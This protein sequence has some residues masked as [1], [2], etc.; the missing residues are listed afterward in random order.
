MSKVTDAYSNFARISS[1]RHHRIKDMDCQKIKSYIEGSGFQPSVSIEGSSVMDQ[2][3]YES[4]DSSERI[5]ANICLYLI[6]DFTALETVEPAIQIPPPYEMT[7]RKN[8]DQTKINEF[9]QRRKELIKGHFDHSGG[10]DFFKRGAWQKRALGANYLGVIPDPDNTRMLSRNYDREWFY[11]TFKFG[12]PGLE[13]SSAYIRWYEHPQVVKEMFPS[14]QGSGGFPQFGDKLVEMLMFWDKDDKMIWADGKLITGVT[15]GYGYVPFREVPNLTNPRGTGGIS[16]IAQIVGIN[17]E[18]NKMFALYHDIISK[19]INTP[20]HVDG[21]YTARNDNGILIIETN[22]GTKVAP[23]PLMEGDV[24]SV[25][26][27]INMLMEMIGKETGFNDSRTGDLKGA[28]FSPG[29]INAVQRRLGDKVDSDMKIRAQREALHCMDIYRGYEKHYPKEII[30]IFGTI[31]GNSY[32]LQ[33]KGEDINGYYAIHLK[34]PPSLYADYS[35]KIKEMQAMADR[36]W[37]SESDAAIECGVW[38]YE[39][40]QQKR[41]QEAIDRAKMELEVQ[42]VMMDQSNNDPNSQMSY[43]TSPGIP[44]AGPAGGQGMP[45]GGQPMLPGAGGAPPNGGKLFPNR[46]GPVALGPG[47]P[48]WPAGMP[49]PNHPAIVAQAYQ[50]AVDSNPPIP[51]YMPADSKSLRV[52]VQDVGEAV[53]GMNTAIHGRVYLIGRI[54][55]YGATGRLV[56]IAITDGQDKTPILQALPELAAQRRIKFFPLWNA[57]EPEETYLEITPGTTGYEPGGPPYRMQYQQAATNNQEVTP[58]DLPANP[59]RPEKPYVS[60]WPGTLGSGPRP[61]VR[62]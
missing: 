17:V 31:E 23:L 21:Q 30:N 24:P 39:F 53:R 36:G 55:D 2:T 40:Q 62:R 14:W 34:Y 9:C 42:S 27:V 7:K 26:Y 20:L 25:T 54:V 61:F 59:A 13:M 11:P 3:M 29:G 1:L 57:Y 46:N 18:M 5:V 8:P 10:I 56:N 45:P 19:K 49:A 15:H 47:H 32:Q 60:K 16:D 12:D 41:K 33:M 58:I 43:G 22:P 37:V 48:D 52:T 35:Y 50:K 44:G 38:N 4:L 6:E 28:Y 51:A